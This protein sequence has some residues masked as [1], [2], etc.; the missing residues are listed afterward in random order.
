MNDF[1][2]QKKRNEIR[3]EFLYIKIVDEL[4]INGD[5]PK[6]MRSRDSSLDDL[7]RS[8]PNFEEQ[9]T[10]IINSEEQRSEI[11]NSDEQRSEIITLFPPRR[12]VNKHNRILFLF[13][14][15]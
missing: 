14:F 2:N 12:H 1:S 3:Q 8:S 6:Q 7:L 13:S 4:N 10:E 9:R 15:F 5:H 11:I